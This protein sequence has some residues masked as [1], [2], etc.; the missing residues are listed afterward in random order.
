M[1][2]ALRSRSCAPPILLALLAAL[3]LPCALSGCGLKG[4]LY[5]PQQKKSRVPESPGNTLPDL[6]ATPAT[7]ATAPPTGAPPPDATTP[8]P[9]APL[10]GAPL[11]PA[12][13]PAPAQ[14]GLAPAASG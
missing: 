5:L 12:P 13:Q 3:C 14:P 9:T 6:P 7:P 10:P 11:P 4:A 8:A 1:N 2:L